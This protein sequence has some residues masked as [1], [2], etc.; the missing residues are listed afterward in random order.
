MSSSIHFIP[1][2]PLP[3][4]LRPN[5]CRGYAGYDEHQCLELAMRLRH[6]QLNNMQPKNDLALL[7][8]TFVLA[9]DNTTKLLP[10]EHTSTHVKCQHSQWLPMTVFSVCE[11]H[12]LIVISA[13][14]MRI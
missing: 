13:H 14:S 7:H 2:S 6:K 11:V 12:H 8:R 5:I 1:L 3:S 9:S 4:P 10:G